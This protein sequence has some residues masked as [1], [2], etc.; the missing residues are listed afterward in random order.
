[1]H[2]KIQGIIKFISQSKGLKRLARMFLWLFGGLILLLLS[3]SLMLLIPSVQ[4]F[5]VNQ[6]TNWLTA[7]THMHAEVGSVRISFPKTIQIGDIY[8]EDQQEDTLLFCEMFSLNADI[9]PLIVQKINIDELLLKGLKSRIY[10]NPGVNSYNFSPLLEAFTAEEKS[11]K[12]S[13]SWQIGFDELNLQDIDLSY[14]GNPDASSFRL[15]LD[16]LQIIDNG[17]DLSNQDFDLEAIELGKT[18]LMLRI[19]DKEQIPQANTKSED[20]GEFPLSLKLGKFNIEETAF[21]LNFT[22]DKLALS[23]YVKKA[24]MTPDLLDLSSQ[25]ISLKEL[26]ADGIDVSLQ[27]APQEADNNSVENKIENTDALSNNF[28]FGNIGWN[29]FTDHLEITNT[30]VL[31][32]LDT[33]AAD[34]SGINYAH[35]G[36]S[37]LGVVADSIYFNK[38]STGAS[39]STLSLAERSGPEITALH[40][41]FSMNNSAISA[42]NMGISTTHSNARGS[43]EVTYPAL[44]LIGKEIAQLGINADLEAGVHMADLN[45][46]IMVDDNSILH[47]LDFVRVD[48]FISSGVLNDLNIKN[49][50]LTF[51]EG[52]LIKASSGIS[53]MLTNELNIVYK[54][55]TAITIIN[56]IKRFVPD[57][58][59]PSD[60]SL[61]PAIF[62]SSSGHTNLTDGAG[63]IDLASDLG[64]IYL[65]AKLSENQL[66]ADLELKELDIGKTINDT[67]YGHINLVS[68]IDANMA[69]NSIESLGAD[70][71]ITSIDFNDYRYENGQLHI[72]WLKNQIGLK[73]QL[74]DSAFMATLNGTVIFQDSGRNI[75]MSMDLLGSDLHA[76]NFS[77]TT[78][79]VSGSLLTDLDIKANNDF[80]GIIR[81]GNIAL[82]DEINAYTIDTI[83]FDADINQN[84]TNFNLNSEIL[85]ASLT[86][87]TRLDELKDAFIDHLD[88]YIQ[89]PDSMV[90]DKDFKFEFELEEDRIG[91]ML[92]EI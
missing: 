81:T 64:R 78:L 24:S 77:D 75:S 73:A 90:N 44:S 16:K 83:V 9:L 55:D 80:R 25:N 63:N 45:L 74:M 76:L 38:N 11:K 49:M 20:D 12:K 89:L 34:A 43:F 60:I 26:L 67:I 37:Q 50:E 7:K 72:D 46:F 71:M 47:K 84:Y 31:L 30:Q 27:V 56:D 32:D 69:N 21:N 2:R 3:L 88:L 5:A 22:S 17:S 61:P 54:I 51:G 53:G 35:L 92:Y 33:L 8:L 19:D 29:L 6:A 14:S 18:S 59:L 65:S 28:T 40:G 10:K 87:N 91:K 4:K 42:K 62:L 66:A 1:M 39:I 70:I 68:H 52:T 85:Q 13:T 48:R 15:L 79:T 82:A 41:V 58:L 36:I 86:G 23:A 57:T